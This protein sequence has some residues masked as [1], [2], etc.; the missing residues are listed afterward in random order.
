MTV[1]TLAAL[2]GGPLGLEL[3]A[4]DLTSASETVLT[5]GSPLF[6]AWSPDGS[7]LALHLG[8][9]RLELLDPRAPVP[10]PFGPLP[11]AFTVPQ[12]MP[13]GRVV[14]S[15]RHA[16]EQR[17]SLLGPGEERRDI[18][19]CGGL[20]RF[21]LS[22]DGQRLAW[23]AS[24]PPVGSSVGYLPAAVP[25]SLVVAD[26]HGGTNWRLDLIPL[27][28]QWSPDGS[29]LLLL[30]VEGERPDV[31]LRWLLWS[32]GEPTPFDSF[33]PSRALA[34]QYLPFF[35]QYAQAL[36]LWSPEGD[37]FTYAGLHPDDATGVWVQRT[38]AGERPRRIADGELASWS[39]Q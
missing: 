1:R 25:G 21:A 5:R 8:E 34:R 17:L 38:V 30:V 24:A 6:V 19:R 16:D 22:S 28:M 9:D 13:D 20:V 33:L 31:A 2:S 3:A 32:G 23:F 39:R 14:A 27:A 29:A 26:L 7:V 37:A 35:D 36:S 11:G 12:W 4:L 15:V 18:A 10:R